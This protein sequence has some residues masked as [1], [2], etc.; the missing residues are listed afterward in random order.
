MN[1][2]LRGLAL[3]TLAISTGCTTMDDAGVVAVTGTNIGLEIGQAPTAQTPALRLGYNRAE[4]AIVSKS[5]LKTGNGSEEDIANVLMELR[6]SNEA[7]NA[8]VYQRLAVGREAVAQSGA[9]LM[10]AKSA[11]GSIDTDAI[12]AVNAFV[13]STTSDEDF[14]RLEPAPVEGEEQE[15]PEPVELEEE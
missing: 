3:A 14:E 11:D 10:F 12:N 7:T 8:G 5:K 1:N 6:Y 2:V 13:D 4:V 9:A 15:T